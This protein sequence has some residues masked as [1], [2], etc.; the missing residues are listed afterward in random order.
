MSLADEVACRAHVG[1]FAH[2]LLEGA[3]IGVAR[4][5]AR[6]SSVAPTLRAS[7]T[8][9]TPSAL[10]LS[11]PSVLPPSEESR[12]NISIEAAPTNEP[13]EDP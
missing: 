5:R 3:E 6:C 9:R 4:M 7:Q 1:H 10:P 11:A 2:P 13:L 12:R 8:A